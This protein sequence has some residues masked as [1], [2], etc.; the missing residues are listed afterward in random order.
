MRI[1]KK[2]GALI[3]LVLAV[4]AVSGFICGNIKTVDE[5]RKPKLIIGDDNNFSPYSFLDS[6]GVAE[7]FN[8]EIAEAVGKA[9]GYNVEIR[10]GEWND[11]R[12]AL[13]AGEI[14]AIAG[15]FY[16]NEREQRYSFTTKHSITNGDIF[17]IEGKS[18]K[19]IGDLKGQTVAVQ[20]GDVVE[21]YLIK[22]NLG[23]KIIEVPTV[24]DA[25][26]L[27]ANGTCDY[28]GVLKLPGLYC[29]KKCNLKNIKAQGLQLTTN[30]YCM[31]VKK[32]NEDLL[33]TLNGGLQ[34]IKANG[35]YQRIY[36]KWL[37][38]YEEKDLFS[39]AKKYS[40]ILMLIGIIILGLIGINMFLNKA[41]Y[42][43]TMELQEANSILNKSNQEI[44]EQKEY[45]N[46]LAFHDPLTNLPNRRK[47]NEKLD[48]AIKSGFG[49][50]VVLLDLDNFK[51]INDT[52]GHVYGDRVLR[53]VAKRL[54]LLAAENVF[55]SR[56]GG[57]EFLILLEREESF[58]K[59]RD[60]VKVVDH[61]FD[62]KILIEENEIEIAF[63]MGVSLF[64]EDSSEAG[65]LIMNAD[66]A[67]YEV[68]NQGKNAYG[69][70]N[71]TMTDKVLR[72]TSTEA[73]IREAIENDGF[74]LVFQPQIRLTDG[75]IHCYEALLRVKGSKISP[76]EFIPVAEESGAIIKIGRIVTRKVI[77]Q[78]S[79]WEKEGHPIKPISLN[80]S[81]AQLQDRGYL[82]YIKGE[83]ENYK[84]N[85]KYIEVEITEN[86]FLNNKDQT[87]IFL[88]K[89]KE[90]GIK[91]S[92][93]DFGTGY[94]SLSYLTFL[95]IDKIKLDRSLNNKFLEME[96][97]KVMDSLI[98]LAH[99]LNLEVVAEGIEFYE[100]FRRLKVG[101]CDY[102]QG[103]FFSKPLEVEAVV[104]SFSV[105]YYELLNIF[106]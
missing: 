55:V 54:E 31:A 58:S 15:M 34:I 41:I 20:K 23:I 1:S 96:N 53:A 91:I 9:M 45:I 59:I 79:L 68:K 43:K 49:G 42:K 25:L 86:I 80:F 98:M 100:Q 74:K 29:E 67:L 82:E 38:V 50:A 99:S 81:A 18:I 30:N 106:E 35:E 28:A 66:L 21:E 8:I 89:L 102:I 70:F 7:G 84:V 48:G 17:A 36:D 52:M 5:L 13:E 87:L 39:I 88:N 10:L 12:R 90:L 75:E 64:P 101:N 33:L 14:D 47:F 19:A 11:I 65:T 16:T 37:G 32:G 63:S 73:L 105:N 83:L 40:G 56:F 76:G 57:D 61:I 93:D 51:A 77:E 26:M 6:N 72:K 3:I 4:L 71:N 62:E 94:S 69:F 22:Q 103:F 85:P 24:E 95:P 97:I 104:E 2:I 78:L 44:L 60:F 46:F 92:I 27:V